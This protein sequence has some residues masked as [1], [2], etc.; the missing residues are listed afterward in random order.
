M[1]HT[2]VVKEQQ[3]ILMTLVEEAPTLF[4]AYQDNHPRNAETTLKSR[5]IAASFVVGERGESRFAGLYEVAGWTFRSAEELD[6][7]PDRHEVMKRFRSESYTARAKRTGRPGREVF[8]LRPLPK[9]GELRGRLVVARPAGRA[10]MRLAENCLLPV[11]Q[12]DREARFVPSAPGWDEFIVTGTEIRGLPLSWAARLREWRGV[13]L[14][15]DQSDGARYVGSAYGEVNLLGR[16]SI[17]VAGDLGVT[18]EL[19]NRDPAGFRFSILE[20]V[21]P[22]APP[23][24]VTKLEASWKQRLDT[25]AWGLNRN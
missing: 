5:K 9:L 1:L 13:Y 19:V 24:V 18:A 8:D 23:D 11:V 20:L 10:Y 14:I 7:D 15:V 25:R 4:E 3:R 6:A 16:W 22:T 21:A 17:H 12:V 2:P